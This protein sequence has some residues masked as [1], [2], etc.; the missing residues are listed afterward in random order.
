MSTRYCRRNVGI[1]PTVPSLSSLCVVRNLWGVG[2]A[3]TAPAVFSKSGRKLLLLLI[4]LLSGSV[5]GVTAVFGRDARLGMTTKLCLFKRLFA[6]CLS[7]R[8]ILWVVSLAWLVWRAFAT[9]ATFSS[10]CR[11]APPDH[12]K[13][14]LFSLD[15]CVV[16]TR[17]GTRSDCSWIRGGSLQV[18]GKGKKHR[19]EASSTEHL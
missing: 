15:S 6:G 8:R 18:V 14:A 5:V 7:S 10:C 13:S 12:T 4:C 2:L 16:L 19:R 17:S 11:R 3:G 1:F 9:A